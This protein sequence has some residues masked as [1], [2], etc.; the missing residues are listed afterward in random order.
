MSQ[1]PIT[2][3]LK[4]TPTL[5]HAPAKQ[6]DGTGQSRDNPVEEATVGGA[7]ETII[8]ETDADKG[9]DKHKLACLAKVKCLLAGHML[10]GDE[11]HLAASVAGCGT[12]RGS[13]RRSMCMYIHCLFRQHGK[14]LW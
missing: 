6:T 8:T 12:Q 4:R 2:S 5:K 11:I 1:L 7:G 10:Q 9:K 13:H 14:P 3:R